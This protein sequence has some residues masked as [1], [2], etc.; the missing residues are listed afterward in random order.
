MAENPRAATLPV[1]RRR[2]GTARRRNSVVLELLVLTTVYLVAFYLLIDPMRRLEVNTIAWV[3]QIFGSHGVTVASSTAL[4]IAPAHQRPILANITASCS[5]L[6]GILALGALAVAVLRG[7][8]AHTLLAY[9]VAA[10][11]LFVANVGRMAL[12]ALAGLTYGT[13]ALVLFH[14]WVGTVWNFIATLLGFLL[15]LYLTLPTAERAEQDRKGRHSAHRPES[16][17]GSGS[18]T[19]SRCWRT[20]GRPAGP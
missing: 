2:P 9:L 17:P 6:M 10:G 7:R 16:G 18:A 8:R 14:D 5:S 19:A 11:L 3:F 20:S 1:R 12:S 4:F 15:L 13:G